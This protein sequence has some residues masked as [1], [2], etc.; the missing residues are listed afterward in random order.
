MS[1]NTLEDLA[2]AARGIPCPTDRA[3]RPAYRV[4]QNELHI[5]YKA[6]CL[7]KFGLTDHPKAEAVWELAWEEGHSEGYHRVADWVQTLAEL[8]VIEGE[9]P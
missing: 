3:L 9:T 6:M 5:Q 1:Y 2:A 4:A 8:M 7:E